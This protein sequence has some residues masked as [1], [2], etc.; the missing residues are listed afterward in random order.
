MDEKTLRTIVAHPFFALAREFDWDDRQLAAAKKLIDITV[1]RLQET[2][3]SDAAPPKEAAPADLCDV[4]ER[5]IGP[6]DTSCCPHCG[7]KW[8]EP[9]PGKKFVAK[10]A[11]P[12]E[13]VEPDVPVK[14]FKQWHNSKY[15]GQGIGQVGPF[16]V[17]LRT[18]RK[19]QQTYVELLHED[20][21]G[22][23]GFTKNQAS[24]L[25]HML[26][27]AVEQLPSDLRDLLDRRSGSAP[28]WTP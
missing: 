7:T 9:F 19:T 8:A 3:T 15:A 13:R 23:Y 4:C 26:Q 10:E 25:I 6:A 2:P 22:G 28:F 21:P 11:A 5:P 27:V 20:D 12:Q 16:R 18:D 14:P 17:V 1:I 24:G